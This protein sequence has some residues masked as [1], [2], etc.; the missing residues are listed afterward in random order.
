MVELFITYL[1]L[2]EEPWAGPSPPA[3]DNKRAQ[4]IWIFGGLGI[5]FSWLLAVILHYSLGQSSGSNTKV[6]VDPELEDG[7]MAT[8]ELNGN[9]QLKKK[10]DESQAR[11]DSP[12]RAE[13]RVQN[14]SERDPLF[15]KA[16]LLLNR[17]PSSCE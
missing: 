3:H 17:Q 16:D 9:I 1:V 8:I 12:D 15:S 5:A 6:A 4:M 2:V 14:I 11:T 7:Q 10:L 13:S